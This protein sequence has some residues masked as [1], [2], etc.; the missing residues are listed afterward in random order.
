M[1]YRPREK[2]R[3]PAITAA[4]LLLL[5]AMSLVLVILLAMYAGYFQV[6]VPSLTERFGP[7]PTPTRP[8]V[9][10]VGDGDTL[11]AAGKLPEAIAA[12]DEAISLDPTDDVPY[13]RQS[14][15]LIFAGDTAKALDRAEQAVLLNSTSAENLANYCRALDWEARYTAAL[16]ACSC[17]TE[18]AP[19]YADG[20]AYL[21]EVLAD[22]GEWFNARDTAQQAL[23]IDFQSFAAHFN[24]GYVNEIQGRY[25]QAVQSYEN[26][27]KLAPNLATAYIAAGRSYYWLGNLNRAIELYRQAIRLSPTNPEAYDRLGWA[28]HTNGEYS[29]AIDALEQGLAVDPT[30]DKAWGHLGLVYYTRQNFE[31]TIEILPKAISLTEGQFLRRA[32]EVEI[33]AEIQTLTGPDTIPVIRGRFR[34]AGGVGSVQYVAELTPLTYKESTLN[35][36]AEEVSCAAS[37]VE[38]IRNPSAL[39]LAPET[40]AYTQTFSQA[41]GTATLNLNSG[42]LVLDVHNVPRP[43][44]TPYELKISYWPDRQDSVGYVQPDGTGQIQVNIQFEEKLDAPIEYYYTLGLAY[45]YMDPPLCEQAVPWLLQSLE[46]DSSGY[47]PAWYGLRICPSAQSPPT[48]VPTWTPVPDAQ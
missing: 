31:K 25:A 28:Y 48:P 42:N 33:R 35:F 45:A 15:L 16:D 13:T 20:Y 24:M 11:A 18:L 21:S 10:Y 40:L 29:R 19:N 5:T 32:R 44:T 27:I 38:S 22:R 9:L 41:T 1:Y 8:A 39:P 2:K 4:L 37:I 26:A 30:Y 36:D 17:A 6:E 34:S 47:N 3:H 12:Y 43:Q 46:R 7:M 23:D 14:R